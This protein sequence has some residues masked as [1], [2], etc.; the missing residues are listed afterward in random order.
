MHNP[1]SVAAMGLIP[2]EVMPIELDIASFYETQNRQR[3]NGRDGKD[4]PPHVH[5][6][7]SGGPPP[8]K[9]ADKSTSVD[10]L[11][12]EPRNE[13]FGTGKIRRLERSRRS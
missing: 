3:K 13:R 9:R 5:S 6:V 2:V 7:C 1:V 12:I 11:R 8:M 4:I 10:A